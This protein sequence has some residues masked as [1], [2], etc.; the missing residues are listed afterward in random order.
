MM[1]TQDRFDEFKQLITSDIRNSDAPQSDLLRSFLLFGLLF[2]K[3]TSQE[4][5]EAKALISQNANRLLC[6]EPSSTAEE[7]FREG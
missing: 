4:L 5:A 2:E 1:T 3:G 7:S 6:V